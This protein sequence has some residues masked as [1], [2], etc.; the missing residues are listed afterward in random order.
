MSDGN[1]PS[2]YRSFERFWEG[3]S[4]LTFLLGIVV[5][6]IAPTWGLTVD[7]GL[8]LLTISI[9]GVLQAIYYDRKAQHAEASQAGTR[10]AS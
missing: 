2:F 10:P 7:D 9:V 1:P 3:I 8:I 6:L 5:W 4:F